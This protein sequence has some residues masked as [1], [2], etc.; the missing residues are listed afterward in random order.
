MTPERERLTSGR[1][2]D[3]FGVDV[4]T[5]KRWASSGKIPAHVLPSGRFVYFLDE[6][7]PLIPGYEQ[8]QAAAS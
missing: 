8:P 3:L 4:S 6:I 1:V 2:A 7:A 5:I